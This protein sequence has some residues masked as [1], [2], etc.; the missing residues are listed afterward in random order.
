MK[1]YP[2]GSDM[3]QRA[4]AVR[5]RGVSGSAYTDLHATAVHG[6]AGAAR[7]EAPRGHGPVTVHFLTVTRP[8]IAHRGTRI[9]CTEL[10]A[11]GTPRYTHHSAGFTEH[12]GFTSLIRHRA[13]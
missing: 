7:A 2:A 5:R 3:Q 1:C 8:R 10:E 11:L 13:I 9:V 4:K 6:P 12:G